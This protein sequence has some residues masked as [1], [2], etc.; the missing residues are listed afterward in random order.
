MTQF[1]GDGSEI[2]SS[3]RRPRRLGLRHSAVDGHCAIGNVTNE[4]ADGSG[5]PVAHFTFEVFDAGVDCGFQSVVGN[6][7]VI[8]IL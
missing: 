3:Q 4:S 2:G 1:L 6:V 5:K 7:D 8:G